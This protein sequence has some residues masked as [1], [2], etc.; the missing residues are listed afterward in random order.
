MDYN[1]HWRPVFKRLP[2]LLDAGL[3]TM[4]VA[5]L[6]MIIGIIAGLLLALARMSAPAPIRWFATSWVE[7]ARNTPVLFQLFFFGFGIGAFGVHLSP[8]FIVLAGLS[9]NNAG[10]L[11]ENFRGGFQ[12]VPKTQLN[13]ARS[14]GMTATQAYVRII[15]PQVLRIVYHPMTN[16]MV[17]AVLMSSLGMM[18]GFR[19]LSGET[20]FFASKTYRIF[21]YFAMTAVIY[22][23]IVKIILGGSK[24]AATRLFRY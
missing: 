22:Y 8:Y 9:F 5:V 24:L 14:L 18:V 16:Q 20:Q 11:A 23:A 10:Y 12:A 3:L 21:E 15:I 17:W 4:E 19:E 13:A 1:F 7:L 6:S 2:E